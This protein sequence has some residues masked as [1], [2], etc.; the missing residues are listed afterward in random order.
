MREGCH[1]EEIRRG[2]DGAKTTLDGALLFLSPKVGTGGFDG[3]DMALGLLLIGERSDRDG[4][5]RPKSR[6]EYTT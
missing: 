2:G 4:W 3:G 1:F 5:C 6:S